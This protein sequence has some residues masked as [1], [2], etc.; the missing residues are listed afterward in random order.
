[1][2]A[3][4]IQKIRRLHAKTRAYMDSDPEVTLMLARKTA[5]A[6]CKLIFLEHISADVGNA[7]LEPL[8]EQIVKGKHLPKRVITHLRTIQV[9]GNFGS[10]DQ[11]DDS[12]IDA[13][14]VTPCVH[15]LDYVCKWF[16]TNLP[17][18]LIP[19]PLI[20]KWFAAEL[21]L[22]PHQLIAELM[23]FNIFLNINQ[24]IS[25]REVIESIAAA[26]GRK[27]KFLD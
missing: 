25:D 20:V 24:S 13:E 7:T 18:I 19:D 6:F 12:F 26:H 23:N 14:Y 8:I 4:G 2:D 21:A 5:E 9:H 17:P 22:K 10:H 16:F 11:E 27:V 3:E 1:M 15:S